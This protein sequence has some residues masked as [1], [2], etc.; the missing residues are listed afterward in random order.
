MERFTPDTKDELILAIRESPE[1]RL[2]NG[3]G[4]I[5]TWNLRNI[6][7]LSFLFADNITFNEDISK[8]DV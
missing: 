7:D 5:N 3:R 1:D 4:N 2:A 6:S 8:W